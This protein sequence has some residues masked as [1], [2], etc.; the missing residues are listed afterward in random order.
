[1]LTS[2]FS[3]NPW[4]SHIAFLVVVFCLDFNPFLFFLLVPCWVFFPFIYLF[5]YSLVDFL[6]VS[7]PNPY[8]S[9]VQV[10]NMPQKSFQLLSCIVARGLSSVGPIL[11]RGHVF[12]QELTQMGHVLRCA[13]HLLLL[14]TKSHPNFRF[15]SMLVNC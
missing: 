4:A 5:T 11:V 6:I 13:H 3:P 8:K 14:C 15:S 9:Y 1:M 7:M 10:V 2:S 12:H